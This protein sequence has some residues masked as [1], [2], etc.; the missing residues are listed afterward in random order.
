MFISTYKTSTHPNFPRM[1]PLQTTT[2]SFRDTAT[3]RTPCQQRH[4]Y[5]T[6]WHY[7]YMPHMGCNYAGWKSAFL[8]VVQQRGKIVCKRLPIHPTRHQGVAA[9]S[10][11]PTRV[12]QFRGYRECISRPCATPMVRPPPRH[13]CPTHCLPSTGQVRACHPC[14]R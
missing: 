14:L 8:A 5:T 6:S 10:I 3:I 12:I 1:N 9:Q 13:H 2:H 7:V 11:I 4:N